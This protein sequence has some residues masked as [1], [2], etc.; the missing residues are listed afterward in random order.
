MAN[1]HA[2]YRFY[3]RAGELLYVGITRDPGARWSRHAADKPWW[4]QVQRIA[5]EPMPDRAIALAA[6]R[7]AIKAE[8]PRYNIVHRPKET[9]HADAEALRIQLKWRRVAQEWLVFSGSELPPC[10]C[11]LPGEPS[12]GDL[13]CVRAMAAYADGALQV[14]QTSAGA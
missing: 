12:C 1:D 2:L 11:N 7:D 14:A 8:N 5:I 6:E 9:P 3:D 4:H 10:E 13:S